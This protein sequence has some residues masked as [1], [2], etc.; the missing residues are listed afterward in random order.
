[1]QSAYLIHALVRHFTLTIAQFER[2]GKVVAGCTQTRR[3]TQPRINTVSL[4]TGL[5]VYSQ[6]PNPAFERSSTSGTP[7][8]G[9]L[10]S[11]SR[12]APPVTAAQLVRWAAAQLQG[13]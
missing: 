8:A 9:L 3:S 4:V 5:T 1:V 12:G 6:P 11:P 2:G 13:R 7:R 10:Y